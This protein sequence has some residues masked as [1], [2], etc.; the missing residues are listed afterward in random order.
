[1]LLSN[2]HVIEKRLQISLF[3]SALTREKA[4]AMLIAL[5]QV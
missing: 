5:D 2:T 4:G 1:M 3:A